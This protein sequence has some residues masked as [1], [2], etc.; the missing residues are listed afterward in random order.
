[1]K[2]RRFLTAILC[3]LMIVCMMPQGV[4]AA[5]VTSLSKV[6]NLQRN[7]VTTKSINISWKGQSG[8]SGYEVYRSKAYNGT[9][10]R[11]KS[12]YA[13]NTAFCNQKLSAG[14]EYYYKVRA[15]KYIDSKNKVYSSYSAV[16][17]IKSK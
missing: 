11:I 1:M 5:S 13:G 3:A 4:S 15:Y 7:T 9:Y 8:V 10:S 14:T 17:S 6:T 16:K 12:I 2:K